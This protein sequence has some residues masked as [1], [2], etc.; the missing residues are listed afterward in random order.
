MQCPFVLPSLV[1]LLEST[2]MFMACVF[3]HQTVLLHAKTCLK[4]S[5]QHSVFGHISTHPTTCHR[6]LFLER[7]RAPVWPNHPCHS[8]CPCA[9]HRQRF[10]LYTLNDPDDT[11]RVAASTKLTTIQDS[12]RLLKK[13]QGE[14]KTVAQTT[15]L[16]PRITWKKKKPTPFA[17][18]H[19]KTR[20][21]EC[22]KTPTSQEAWWQLGSVGTGQL[23]THV[24]RV[25]HE[26][27]CRDDL[28]KKKKRTF[29][30]SADGEPCESRGA[31][32]GNHTAMVENKQAKLD[33]QGRYRTWTINKVAQPSRRVN[34]RSSHAQTK[35]CCLSSSA[36]RSTWPD[37][38]QKTGPVNL[39]ESI[40]QV[41]SHE[42]PFFVG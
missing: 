21:G 15:Q 35:R 42:A 7:R 27:T 3:L 39:V 12:R 33:K 25:G 40:L 4:D 30:T 6:Q 16:Q 23:K 14:S 36:S 22:H 31:E 18:P 37:L 24:T 10:N 2:I 11:W 19:H 32:K 8:C 20:C 17:Q 28:K 5:Q 26:A 13:L 34:N 1:W 41:Q 29:R 38:A 9:T